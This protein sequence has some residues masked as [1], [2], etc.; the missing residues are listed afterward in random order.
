MNLI[1]A[2]KTPSVAKNYDYLALVKAPNTLVAK[3]LDLLAWSHPATSAVSF[4]PSR[5][6]GMPHAVWEP[7]EHSGTHHTLCTQASARALL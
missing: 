7:N 4:L 2:T 3:A 6:F 5:P 1:V